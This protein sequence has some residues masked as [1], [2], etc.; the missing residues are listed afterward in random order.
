MSPSPASRR[1]EALAS[2]LA[3]GPLVAVV[4][5]ERAEDAVPLAQALVGGGLRLLEITL[6][7]PSALDAARAILAEVPEAV[8]GL[9][10]VLTP[11]DLRRCE[12]IGARFA[13]SPGATPALLEAASVSGLPFIPGVATASELMQAAARGFDLVKFFPAVAAGGIP[14]LQ[15]LAGPFPEMRFCPTG[16]I[17][18]ENAAR[19]LALPNVVALGGSWLAPAADIRAGRWAAITGRTRRALALLGSVG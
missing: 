15:A 11:D 10:T 19:W 6:R 4:T 13:L 17:T 8:V 18:E 16:G 5:V 2:I 12:A 3:A 7:T 9:G 14:V 1:A